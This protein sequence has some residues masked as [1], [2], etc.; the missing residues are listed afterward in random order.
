ML[1]KSKKLKYFPNPTEAGTALIQAES[2]D[3]QKVLLDLNNVDNT[4]DIDKPISTSQQDALNLKA[5]LNSP[6][7]TGTPTSPTPTGGDN[8]ENIATTAFVQ[9]AVAGGGSIIA[10]TTKSLPASSGTEQSFSIPGILPGD[11]VQMTQL[12]G[13]STFV[14]VM[15]QAWNDGTVHVTL[16]SAVDCSFNVTVLR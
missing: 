9:S 11:I 10:N 15:A 6:T 2:F 1:F 4:S 13:G 3:D 5:N 14:S 7:L 8:S 16:S 12:H